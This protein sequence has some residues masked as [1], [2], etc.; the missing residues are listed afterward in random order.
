M[1]KPDDTQRSL[2]T[3]IVAELVIRTYYEAQ[4]KRTYSVAGR[5]GFDRS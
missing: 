5:A 3:G 2:A 4:D 1:S